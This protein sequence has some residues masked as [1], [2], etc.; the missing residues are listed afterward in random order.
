MKKQKHFHQMSLI[1]LLYKHIVYVWSYFTKSLFREKIPAEVDRKAVK[2]KF[3]LEI[4]SHCW[5]YANMLTYQLS[6]F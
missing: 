4:V 1:A 5:G 2:G 3:D 6:S